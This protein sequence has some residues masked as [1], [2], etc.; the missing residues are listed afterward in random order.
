MIRNH[1]VA[2]DSPA[3]VAD[4]MLS[5]WG[6]RIAA[7]GIENIGMASLPP[8]PIDFPAP[9]GAGTAQQED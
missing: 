8:G 4:E 6:L 9:T 5:D 2:D 7:A 1:W 3:E